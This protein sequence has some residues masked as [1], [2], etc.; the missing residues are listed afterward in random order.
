MDEAERIQAFYRK[1]GKE[2][3]KHFEHGSEEDIK[4]NMVPLKPKEWR[5]EG[6]LLIAETEHGVH[7]QTIPTDY[8]LAGTDNDGLPIFRKVV[9]S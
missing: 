9:L 6:N 7:A 2:P 5:M 1:H 4:A 3:P 8:I